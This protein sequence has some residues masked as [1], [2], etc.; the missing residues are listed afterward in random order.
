MYYRY[1][2]HRDRIHNVYAHYGVRT[3]RHKLIY[4]YADGLGQPGSVGDP[5]PPEWELFDLQSDPRELHNVYDEPAYA[6]TVREL[7]DELARLQQ[8]VGDEPH[9]PVA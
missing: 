7:T 6:D 1:W 5:C 2:M 3:R 9:E 4:Y 8:A